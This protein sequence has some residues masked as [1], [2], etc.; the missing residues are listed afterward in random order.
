MVGRKRP[1]MS[2]DEKMER[3]LKPLVG[4][5]REA[6]LAVL[7]NQQT[8]Q[9]QAAY[10]N[11]LPRVQNIE[12]KPQAVHRMTR[13]EKMERVLKPLVGKQR[14]EMATALQ[15]VPTSL[16][17]SGYDAFIERIQKLKE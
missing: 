15:I 10:D 9:L 2:R 12:E 4:K 17:Q 14:D 1:R 7:Q 13:D 5:Q 11:A 8:S 3:V 16:L 6:M